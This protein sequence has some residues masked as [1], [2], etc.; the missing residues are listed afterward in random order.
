MRMIKKSKLKLIKNPAVGEVFKN[1]PEQIRHKLMQLRQLILDTASEIEDIDILE[2][3][4][5]WGE[6]SY[7]VKKGSTVR[8]DY[9]KTKPEQYAMYFKCTSQLVSTF[10]MIYGDKFSFEGNRAIVFKITDEIPVSELKHCISLA[11]TYHRIKH[12]GSAT[13]DRTVS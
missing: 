6:P 2:E 3:T 10:K 11:L 9:K 1:Y 12:F 7:L 13:F 5:K 8:I 4:L